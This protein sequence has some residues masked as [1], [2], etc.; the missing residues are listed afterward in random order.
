MTRHARIAALVVTA[1][2]HLSWSRWDNIDYR[3]VSDVK[4]RSGR[5]DKTHD[6]LR[7]RPVF[8]LALVLG[9][10]HRIEPMRREARRPPRRRP[11]KRSLCVATRRLLRTHRRPSDTD[12]P[13]GRRRSFRRQ[14]RHR[15]SS[16]SWAT[17]AGAARPRLARS[18]GCSTASTATSCWPATWRIRAARWT[19]SS[20][21]S[22]RAS[23]GSSRACAPSPGN[24]D[25]VASVSAQS[26]FEYFGE[27]SGPTRLGYYSYRAAEWTVM[28]LNSNVPIGRNSPQYAFVRET[29]QQH[30]DAVHD[31]GAAS[32]VRQ[33]RR[34]R[35]NAGAARCVGADVQRSAPIW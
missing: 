3:V 18:R 28:M 7:L 27:R 20:N 33:L 9:S 21:A 25:Y 17:P 32:S 12:R 14:V 23:A 15:R 19:S 26:Y 24:H 6:V 5:T 2:L 35:A 34:E 22:S 30:A 11:S 16:M 31:G 10:A 4:P 13:D 1:V 29:M 8:G